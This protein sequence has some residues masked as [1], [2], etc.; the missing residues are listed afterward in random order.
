MN[1]TYINQD[2]LLLQLKQI[3]PKEDIFNLPTLSPYLYSKEDMKSK[4]KIDVQILLD[5]TQI[6]LLRLES[7]S[8]SSIPPL[9][10]IWR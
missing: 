3:F 1:S 4:Q 10:L 8:D 2:L 7:K 6:P 9:A 5:R